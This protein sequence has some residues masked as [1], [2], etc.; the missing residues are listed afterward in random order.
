MG[1]VSIRSSVCPCNGVE[2]W[3]YLIGGSHQLL[4]DAGASR[5]VSLN[6]SGR[7]FTNSAA[8]AAVVL[9]LFHTF[10]VTSS[11]SSSS[12]AAC[13]LIGRKAC[14][15][16]RPGQALADATLVQC[17]HVQPWE[18]LKGQKNKES[19][20]VRWIYYGEAQAASL[21]FV[22]FL[23][24]C[25]IIH[26]HTLNVWYLHAAAQQRRKKD[27][28]LVEQCAWPP[29]SSSQRFTSVHQSP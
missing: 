16:V 20:R 17:R 25:S 18:A 22:N 7:R 9:L 6:N 26:A 3:F 15:S 5:H 1:V 8:A 10:L 2:F 19:R 11:H 28:E 27:K 12:P 21:L 14:A 29:A 4:R 13:S 24:G 23:S